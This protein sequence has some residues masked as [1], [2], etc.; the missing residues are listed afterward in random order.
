M[1]KSDW[2][3]PILLTN[4][5]IISNYI[6]LLLQSSGVGMVLLYVP[7]TPG[8]FHYIF[9]WKQSFQAYCEPGKGIIWGKQQSEEQ[10]IQ[11]FI[12][13]IF[14]DWKITTGKLCTWERW[15]ELYYPL[16]NAGHHMTNKMV[17]ITTSNSKILLSWG[18]TLCHW[19]NS[20]SHFEGSW[21][22]QNNGSC[23][24]GHNVTCQMISNFSNTVVRSS[25]IVFTNHFHKSWLRVIMYYFNL[26][27]IS[28]HSHI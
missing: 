25:N 3:F 26:Y 15:A 6:F 28:L 24:Q 17:F 27:L 5:S 18:V 14:L 16:H 20:S 12:W 13:V 23:T 1:H 10:C 7:K 9:S 8:Y 4:A 19:I 2:V 22:L 21:Y 11:L